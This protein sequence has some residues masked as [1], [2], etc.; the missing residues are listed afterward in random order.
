MLTEDVKLS[1]VLWQSVN[2]FSPLGFA[3]DWM[4][5]VNG[6]GLWRI[7]LRV[8]KVQGGNAKSL[9]QKDKVFLHLDFQGCVVILPNT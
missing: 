6:L 7:P 1:G 2:L 9:R 8:P 5:T 3:L 4:K